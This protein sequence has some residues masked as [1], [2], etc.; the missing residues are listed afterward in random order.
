MD[1]TRSGDGPSRLPAG[2]SIVG[3]LTSDQDL[4]IDGQYD[5]HITLLEQHL[6]IAESASVKGK[7][8]ARSVTVAGKLDG[9]VIASVR[10]DLRATATVR[11]HLQTPSI[12]IDEGARFDGSVD[13]S[14]TAAA[15]QVARY[16]QKR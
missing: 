10:V 3:D 7:V 13:P 6:T 14:R 1:L 8:V 9:N 15:M 2:L 11:A 4:T 12:V 5:G 16:R